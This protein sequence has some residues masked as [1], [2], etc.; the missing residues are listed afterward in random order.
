MVA[1][2]SAPC[3][4]GWV[5]S[6]MS[7][8]LKGPLKLQEI[9]LF[10]RA[11]KVQHKVSSKLPTFSQGGHNSAHFRG[12]AY[13]FLLSHFFCTCVQ[14]VKWTEVNSTFQIAL[15]DINKNEFW[16]KYTVARLVMT[17]IGVPR[18]RLSS[19]LEH[20]QGSQTSCLS[21]WGNKLVRAIRSPWESLLRATD[22]K[23][24]SRKC[25]AK[26][27]WWKVKEAASAAIFL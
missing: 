1:I 7:L 8:C 26:C 20:E 11:I 6:L 2:D 9:S 10:S 16:H 13:I 19:W 12:A 24:L 22:I 18:C 14:T 4:V 21:A 5:F 3:M 15:K 23:D 17:I 27:H 25:P